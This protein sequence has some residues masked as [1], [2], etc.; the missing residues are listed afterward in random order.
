MEGSRHDT[1]SIGLATRAQEQVSAAHR[2]TLDHIVAF[3]T[4]KPVATEDV[5]TPLGE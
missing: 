4:P 3:M 5:E 1:V 2:Y